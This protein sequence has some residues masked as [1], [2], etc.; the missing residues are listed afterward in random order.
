MHDNRTGRTP[1]DVL[2]WSMIADAAAL[3]IKLDGLTR[4]SRE[5]LDEVLAG[6]RGAAGLPE[7]ITPT[8]LSAQDVSAEVAR[9]VADLEE[10]LG[11]ADSVTTWENEAIVARSLGDRVRLEAESLPADSALRVSLL[12][13]AESWIT[14]ARLRGCW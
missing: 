9:G 1:A 6:S 2:A 12:E 4:E 10:W 3:A 13:T 14:F 5:D 7:A 11:R 8:D